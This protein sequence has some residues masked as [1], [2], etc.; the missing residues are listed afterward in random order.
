MDF[1]SMIEKTGNEE[2]RNE[3]IQK[4]YDDRIIVINSDIGEWLLE[5]VILHIINW[6]MEDRDIPLEKRKDIILVIDSE[7]GSVFSSNNLVDVIRSS[8]TKITAVGCSM[9]ASA[10]FSIFIACHK[11]YAFKHTS[12]LMH[13]SSRQLA[14]SAGKMRDWMDF[15]DELD[16]VDKQLVIERTNVTEE[17][18]EKFKRNEVLFFSNEAVERGV[19]DGIIGEDVYIDEIF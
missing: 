11:R 5:D 4:F 18:Y 1:L 17:E 2:I 13:E 12:F 8:K 10:A 14:N 3:I 9:V 16:D 15:L 7:G 19:V 6:N